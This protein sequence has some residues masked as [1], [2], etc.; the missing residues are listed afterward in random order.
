M[1]KKRQAKNNLIKFLTDDINNLNDGRQTDMIAIDMLIPYANHPFKLYEGDRFNDM[2]RSIGE[3]GV[4][5]PVIVRP[6]DSDNGQY[7]ILSGH[8][9]VNAARMAGLIEV[10]V[11]VR[12]DLSDDDA[13]LI[14]T[15]TNLVQR[16]FTDLAHSERAVV[17]KTHLDAIKAQGRRTDIINEINLLLNADEY[18]EN[19]TSNLLD[20]KSLSVEKTGVKYELSSASVARYIRVTYLNNSLQDRV[21]KEE[22]GLYSAVSISYLTPDEQTELSRILDKAKYRIDMKKA[23]MLREYSESKKLSDDRIL[24]IL[25]GEIGKKNRTKPPASFKINYKIYSKY[26]DETMKQGEIESIIDK[27]LEEYFIKH[28]SQEVDESTTQTV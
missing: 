13:K 22:I 25:S 26:F 3:I 8:N 21:N 27:S 2:V 10:P 7:E 23:K 15:E 1:D 4:L 19:P 18:R 28:K 12:R 24:Q 11:I 17:L 5:M 20:E 16:S 14:V 6:A 9:R